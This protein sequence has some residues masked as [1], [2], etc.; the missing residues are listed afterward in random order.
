MTNIDRYQPGALSRSAGQSRWVSKALNRLD[1]N[2]ELGLARVEATAELEAVKCDAVSFVVSRAM[3]N[4]T[5]IST[6]EVQ[7]AQACPHASARLALIADMGSLALADLVQQT[8]HRV[9]TC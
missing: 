6:L 3:H 9:R 7:L 4:V 5:L 8:A 2:T 1:G